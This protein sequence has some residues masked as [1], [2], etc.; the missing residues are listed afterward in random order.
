MKL[1]KNFWLYEFIR[2]QTASRHGIDNTPSTTAIFEI[3]SLVDNVLQPLRDLIGKPI[4]INSGFRCEKLN[5]AIGGSS[6][7]QHMYGQAADIESFGYSNW[8]LFN[9]IRQNFYFD[10]LI[11]EYHKPQEGPNSGWVHVSFKSSSNNE[12]FVKEFQ[13]Q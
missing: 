3:Q 2:S 6:N 7:S 8:A 1:S 9:A 5:T 10:Q 12:G 4:N 13:N 11:L